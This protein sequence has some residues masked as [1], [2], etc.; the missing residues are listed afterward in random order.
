MKIARYIEPNWHHYC[1][2]YQDFKPFCRT[3]DDLRNSDPDRKFSYLATWDASK[4]T[5]LALEEK[6]RSHMKVADH[7]Y[8]DFGE[9][10]LHYKAPTGGA[11][12]STPQF[13]NKFNKE[14][15]VTFFG[16][17]VPLIPTTRPHHYLNDMF[18]EGRDIYKDF[19][20]CKE[21]LGKLTKSFE[22]KFHWEMMCSHT[23]WLYELLQK[24][25]VNDFTFSTCHGLGISHWGPDVPSPRNGRT[26]AETFSGE[27]NIRVSDLIDPSIYNQSHFSC[28]VETNVLADNSAA[29]FSEKEAKPIVARRPFIIYGVKDQLKAFRSLGFRTFSPV[30]D[31]SYDDEPDHYDRGRR[32]FDAMEKLTHKDPRDVY[33]K[34]APVLEHNL[35]HFYN[36][37]WNV[38]FLEAW[39]QGQRPVI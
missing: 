18:F 10:L 35:N 21:L 31:E 34:L 33:E 37:E 19:A 17:S 27:H 24:H 20:I 28:V 4:E 3:L 13:I 16:N 39:H 29:M 15:N 36:N 32:V 6:I 30:I 38:E 25:P 1:V 23:T 5:A 12:H 14:D 22:K 11:Y 8:V 7:V 26:G 2:Q 9:P